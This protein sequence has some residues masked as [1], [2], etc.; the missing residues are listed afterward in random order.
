MSHLTPEIM[1][2]AYARGIFPMAEGRRDTTLFWVD[3]ELRGI[4]PLNDFHVPKRLKRTLR[5]PPRVTVDRAFQQVIENCAQPT[6]GRRTTWIN[7]EIIRLYCS[8]HQRG[9][10]HSLE[11]WH[12]QTLVGGLYGLAVGG[13]FFGESMFSSQADASKVALVYLVARLKQGGYRLLDTQFVTPHLTTF[14]AIEIARDKYH[15][16]LTEAIEASGDF[17]ALPDEAPADEVLR[18][19]LGDCA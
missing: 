1:L 13:A 14:G 18:L 11:V 7:D 10:A 15:A 3:P 5:Q 17:L 9:H 6:P 2:Q 12:E 16:L 4:I 19:A 8:L